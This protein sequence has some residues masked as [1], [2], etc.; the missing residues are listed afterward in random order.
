M[1]VLPPVTLTLIVANVVSFI[2]QVAV[3]GLTSERAI[4]DAGALARDP[5]VLDGEVWRVWSAAFLHGGVDHLLGN[6]LP[7]YIVGMALEHAIGWWATLRVYF[8][9]AT[10]AS[11]TS[12]LVDPGPS[13]GASGAIFGLVGALLVVLHRHKAVLALRDARVLGVL[14]AW[15]ALMLVAGFASPH[16][17]NAAHVGGLVTG[18]LIGLTLE[19]RLDAPAIAV[20]R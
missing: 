7:L 15:S 10:L 16:I 5:V 14:G 8:L 12:L 6:M 13:L 9:A 19:L 17:D 18:A 20:S 4:V 1:R 3:H 2:H 11:I